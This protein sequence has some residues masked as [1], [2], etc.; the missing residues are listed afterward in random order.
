MQRVL[1]RVPVQRLTALDRLNAI[2]TME[3]IGKK[4]TRK[5]GRFLRMSQD[6]EDDNSLQCAM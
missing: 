2:M 5:L 6:E 4:G 1:E 3:S